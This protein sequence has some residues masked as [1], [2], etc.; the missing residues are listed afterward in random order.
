[1]TIIGHVWL[2][3]NNQ[4]SPCCL[5][6]LHPGLAGPATLRWQ[7]MCTYKKRGW[8]DGQDGQV[9]A[10]YGDRAISPVKH[11]QIQ[12]EMH[13]GCAVRAGKM[14]VRRFNQPHYDGMMRFEVSFYGSDWSIVRSSSV[15]SSEHAFPTKGRGKPLPPVSATAFSHL[16]HAS[17]P[18]P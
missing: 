3:D 10:V 13:H 15:P 2:H 9:D 7:M 16:V 18:W 4:A 12:Q 17:Q 11:A 8:Q 1:M 6:T 14:E 5:F